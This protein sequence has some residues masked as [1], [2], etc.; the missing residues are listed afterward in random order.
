MRAS[1][2]GFILC[3]LIAV[4]TVLFYLPGFLDA[5]VWYSRAIGRD[6]RMESGT[7]VVLYLFVLVIAG[8]VWAL[9]RPAGRWMADDDQGE[10]LTID[11]AQCAAIGLALLGVAALI[12]S[13][14]GLIPAIER[15]IDP[16]IAEQKFLFVFFDGGGNSPLLQAVLGSLLLAFAP[17]LGIWLENT[18][19]GKEEAGN[20]PS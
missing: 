5:M 7:R 19:A 4:G 15:A 20:E 18:G 2:I 16:K 1:R 14:N 8:V 6:G 11:G 9:A 10:K 17:R 12:Y 13:A 3:R